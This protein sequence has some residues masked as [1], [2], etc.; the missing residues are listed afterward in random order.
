MFFNFSSRSTSVSSAGMNAQPAPL[1]YYYSS[2][3]QAARGNQDA[4]AIEQMRYLD[5]EQ[6]RKRFIESSTPMPQT[7]ANGQPASP[8][9]PPIRS[10]C[11]GS[12]SSAEI[13]SGTDGDTLGNHRNG[14]NGL[15]QANHPPSSEDGS[16]FPTPT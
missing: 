14:K 1:G 6:H 11:N 12:S 13:S 7:R 16:S 5:N 15:A 9:V 8:R 3:R 10:R 2:F 4:I